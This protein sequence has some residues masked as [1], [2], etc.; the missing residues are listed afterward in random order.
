MLEQNRKQFSDNSER[1]KNGLLKL[2][3]AAEQVKV[4]Q[5]DLVVKEKEVSI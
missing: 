4:L 3:E 2:E 1:Y 5:A